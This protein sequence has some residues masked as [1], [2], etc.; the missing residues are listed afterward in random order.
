MQVIFYISASYKGLA[1]MRWISVGDWYITYN[2][3]DNLNLLFAYKRIKHPL[4]YIQHW[5]YDLPII[6]F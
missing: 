5:F 2:A 4:R 3:L 1:A 6:G